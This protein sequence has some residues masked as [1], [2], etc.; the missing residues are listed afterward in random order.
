[1]KRKE[2]KT[3]LMRMRVRFHAGGPIEEY[4]Q[5]FTHST[6]THLSASVSHSAT[7]KRVILGISITSHLYSKICMSLKECRLLIEALEEQRNLLKRE[8]RGSQ[9][10]LPD[11]AQRGS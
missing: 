4:H 2:P 8:L 11:A 10:Q 3:K 9:K 6:D 1:M 5:I 7:L